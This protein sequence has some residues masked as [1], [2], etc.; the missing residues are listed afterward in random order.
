MMNAYDPKLGQ[1]LGRLNK[2]QRDNEVLID[3]LRELTREP[4]YNPDNYKQ[5]N[6]FP[7]RHPA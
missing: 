7:A 1:L 5:F 6:L 2:L 4:V 3:Q